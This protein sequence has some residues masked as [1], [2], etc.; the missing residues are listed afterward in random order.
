MAEFDPTSIGAVPVETF[1]PKSI[2]AVPVESFDPTS[3]G[4]VPVATK[5]EPPSD[6]REF[7]TKSDPNALSPFV[8][9]SA[10]LD[11]PAVQTK[12]QF[13]K[14]YTDPL[15]NLPK[16][17]N[18][19]IVSGIVRGTESAVEGLTSPLNIALA[20]TATALPAQLQ[21]LVAYWFGAM[22]TKQIPEHIAA[23]NEAQTPGEKAEAAASGAVNAGLAALS[24]AHGASSSRIAEFARPSGTGQ[25]VIDA[26]IR[27]AS[28]PQSNADLNDQAI[29]SLVA[30]RDAAAKAAA[31]HPAL[32]NLADNLAYQLKNVPQDRINE[33][34]LRT[35]QPEP[36]TP[37]QGPPTEGETPPSPASAEPT[38]S[39]VPYQPRIAQAAG[40]IAPETAAAASEA[41]VPSDERMQKVVKA[42]IGGLNMA[43]DESEALDH[44][45]GIEDDNVRKAIAD[46]YG[47]DTEGKSAN[48]LNTEIADK[49]LQVKNAT[50]PD[51][52]T[53]APAE[54]NPPEEDYGLPKT[55]L[56]EGGSM[57]QRIA[58]LGI[59]PKLPPF[60]EH[61]T[62]LMAGVADLPQFKDAADAFKG[63]IGSMAGRTFPNTTV[64]D[65]PLGELGARWVSSKIAAK[66]SAMLFAS[67][68]MEGLGVDPAKF[69]AAL[70][71]DNLRSIRNGFEQ[72]GD[73]D[74]AADV[75]TTI[76][77]KGSPFKSESDYQDFLNDPATKEALQ[78]HKAMWDAVID[79]MYRNA[80]S[81][82]PD[83]ELPERGL[84]TGAR[85]NLHSIM[86]GE[87]PGDK[88]TTVG[89]GNLLGTMRRKSIFGRQ[90]TGA[91]ETYGSNY[92]GI[93]EN[94]FAKQLEI[95]N[96]NAFEDALVEKG[97]AKVD[98][99]GQQIEI[100]GRKAASFPYKRQTLIDP[101]SGTI[102]QSKNLY[103]DPRL[104]SEYKSGSNILD[105]GIRDSVAVKAF[106]NI[107]NNA[108]LTGL[109]DATV[110]V[111][112]LATAL[113][114]R[115]GGSLLKDTLL[116]ATG[117]A[118]IPVTIAKAVMKGFSD[119]SAQIKELSEIGAM[120]EDHPPGSNASPLN[121]TRNLIQ[122]ADKTA[123]LTLDDTYKSL[124]DSGLVEKNETNRRE[125]VNQVGQYNK[126]AQPAFMRILR[127]SGVSPFVTAGKTFNA[128][129][130]KTATLNPGLKAASLPA[131]TALRVNQLSKW[132]GASALVGTLNYLI[133]GKVAGRA[134]VPI[135]AIDTG[136]S[137]KN[138]R[139][140]YIK[141]FDM[142]GLGR[143]MRVTGARGL[144]NSQRNGLTTG[145]AVNSAGRDMFN[146]AT[147][148]LIG[149]PVRFLATM[150][151]IP[152]AMGIGKP[153]P[154]VA[155]GENQMA[156]NTK[157]AVIQA[158][159]LLASIVD[160]TKTG[161]SVLESMQRQF[162][163]YL[164][165]SGNPDSVMSKYPDIV[166]RAQAREF[167]NDVI[168]QARKMSPESKKA[169]I[170][171]SEQRLSPADREQFRRTLK[172]SHVY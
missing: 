169:F 129:A 140:L 59:T 149:P 77:A 40:E 125:F 35:Q 22:M 106:S 170:D 114:T 37:P 122:W 144:I 164:P 143:A 79:P 16:P 155:P 26:A 4:A 43:A 7:L 94:T 120:R 53:P 152:T 134:G 76:G 32:Q 74:K 121:W 112:N 51:E 89:Q 148:P 21:K 49:A 15:L 61:L 27:S 25:Q 133:T 138:N 171:A 108:A 147:G 161:G 5:Q 54:F 42:E 81:I 73:A 110:H 99:P 2:G 135:G 119:N 13:E 160:R 68:V 24:I 17:A 18:T 92:F 82:D 104:Q 63:W 72:S 47:I 116:S 71:E 39:Q 88:I 165:Q 157:Q 90:A 78:R 30:S 107:T 3:I 101:S 172:Y 158:S 132:V 131:A 33:S 38:T 137:D 124:A 67:K 103:L 65:R 118:D 142:M 102:S 167:T 98:K 150:G 153:V 86:E 117:R 80:M 141:A 166:H 23:I 105:S 11:N 56:S 1:D 60:V 163:R 62:D 41:G 128:L 109:T 10:S 113:F 20:A 52:S 50:R 168:G 84:Q 46:Q 154:A 93:M 29:D 115:P 83:T 156:A 9:E 146:A 87:T 58:P 48:D 85:I 45:E 36:P 34:R 44:M 145:D 57:T 19:G 96:K 126:R 28:E 151:N 97:F 69:G 123:R 6:L 55:K 139:P 127:D 130:V 100:N 75:K 162:P 136:K 66:P 95:A 64:L 12:E 31:D 70:T 14:A 159:P 8:G 91:G 111:S